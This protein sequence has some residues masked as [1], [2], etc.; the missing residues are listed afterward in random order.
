[1]KKKLIEACAFMALLVACTTL[2]FSFAG[3]KPKLSTDTERPIAQVN[4]TAQRLIGDT[5]PEL[6]DTQPELVDTQPE[7]PDRSWVTW[8]ECS[9]KVGDHPCNFNLMD[10]HG[11]MVELYAQHEKVIVID[12]STMWCAICNNIA[13]EGDEWV[14]DYGAD[15]FIWLTILIDNA[16]GDPPTLAD[17]QS[18]ATHYNI[19]VPVL[20][21]DRS[22]VDLTA[23]T[24]YPVTGWPTLVVIDQDMVLQY[25]INGWNESV[26]R[27]WVQ[28]LL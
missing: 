17:I 3:C 2:A 10:Q 28:S 25:G 18:W 24:G 13:K 1:M 16:T 20:V 4:D 12:L 15:N 7:P 22:L 21:G 9:Q 23:E 27:G 14:N 11:N 26:I 19:S 8:T 6:G 5:Q